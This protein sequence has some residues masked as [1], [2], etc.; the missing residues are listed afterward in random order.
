[1]HGNI[2]QIPFA[3]VV[4]VVLGYVA[5]EY[6]IFWSIALHIIN[7][8]IFGD[9]WN[10]LFSGFSENVQTI[11]AYA[12]DGIF[13]VAALVI[14]FLQRKKILDYRRQSKGNKQLYKQFFLSSGVVLFVLFCIAET[15]ILFINMA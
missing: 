14:L 1:M 9:I 10:Y 4:G 11:M 3:I 13:F 6:S 8:C 15:V 12:R 5:I 2:M 7:N